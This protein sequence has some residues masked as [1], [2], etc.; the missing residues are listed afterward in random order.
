MAENIG[1]AGAAQLV[2]PATSEGSTPRMSGRGGAAPSAE[3]RTVGRVMA[4]LEVVVA[5]NEQGIRLADLAD[6]LDAPKSSLHALA[7]GLISTGYLREQDGRYVVGP[8]IP[9]LI[10][11]GPSTVQFAYRH[12]LSDLVQQWN[13]TAMLATFVGE[14]IVYVDSVQ[15]DVLICA[16]P[17]LNKRLSLWPRSSGKVFLAH[18][19][20]KRLEAYLRRHHPDPADADR[21]RAE[22]DITRQTGA[23]VSIGESVAGHIAI[24]VPVIVRGPRLPTA[25]AIAIAGPKSRMEDQVEQIIEGLRQAVD[26]IRTYDS[27]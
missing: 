20:P 17:A 3:H 26:H 10:A 21:V 18:M 5:C 2:N 8:A 19:E 13:E 16:S 14:S 9:S 23:G 7:K 4:M 6:T 1:W 22:L 27:R 24:S 11:V 12:I 25:I 15:P